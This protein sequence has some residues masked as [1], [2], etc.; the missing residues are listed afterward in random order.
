[1]ASFSTNFLIK[2]ATKS[3]KYIETD[4]TAERGAGRLIVEVSPNG[5]KRFYFRYFFDGKKKLISICKLDETDAKNSRDYARN[6]ADEYSDY[7]KTGD[8]P[9]QVIKEKEL[10]KERLVAVEIERVRKEKAQGSFKQLLDVYLD[11]LKENRGDSH[12]N[13][14]RKTFNKGELNHLYEHKANKVTKGDVKAVLR[15][16]AERDLLPSA[17]KMRT[18]LL[19][20]FNHAIRSENSILSMP[21]NIEFYLEANPVA[22]IPQIKLGNIRDRR[23]DETEI[24]L[25]WEYLSI[26]AGHPS[27]RLLIKFILATGGQRIK[28]SALLKWSEIKGDLWECPADNTKNGTTSIVVLNQLALDV[29]GEVAHVSDYVFFGSKITNPLRSDSAQRFIRRSSLNIDNFQVK[30]LRTTFKT[31]GGKIGITKQI[32]DKIQHHADK[33]VSEKH[34][35]FYD[36]LD[37]KRHAMELWGDYL[38][39][40]IEGKEIGS[41][42]VEFKKIAVN[43]QS[44]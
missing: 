33:D 7:L 39:R 21:S 10:E 12:F 44:S 40:I 34:Y 42:V 1:M 31:L 6:K 13:S 28:Q 2:L 20:A 15:S 5:L 30:D 36:Y 41:N 27:T 38:Q 18:Y 35:D 17:N 11:F 23:L 26:E 43:E 37:E 3:K 16:I 14:V 32:R 25:L 24:K 29:L 19:G 22:S 4:D 8:D 9:K